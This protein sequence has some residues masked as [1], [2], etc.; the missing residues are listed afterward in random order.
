MKSFRWDGSLLEML[1]NNNLLN[2][3]INLREF[4]KKYYEEKYNI[5]FDFQAK[6]LAC[7]T[8]IIYLTGLNIMFVILGLLF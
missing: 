6:Y 4:P 5:N 2:G 3:K 7:H 1:K 8:R